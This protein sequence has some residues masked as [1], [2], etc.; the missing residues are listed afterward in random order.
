MPS[1][2]SSTF[3]AV[4]RIATIISA[5]VIPI[6]SHIQE[7]HHADLFRLLLRLHAVNLSPRLKNQR[8]L[9]RIIVLQQ[10]ALGYPNLK[11]L[12]NQPLEPSVRVI[13]AFAFAA[14]RAAACIKFP[15]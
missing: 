4:T 3:S 12:R 13:L 5:F 10:F 2:V 9:I 7:L 8:Q 15:I 14:R 11:P 1:S 6:T